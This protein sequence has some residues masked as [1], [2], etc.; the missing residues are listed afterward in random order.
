VAHPSSQLD[1]DEAVRRQLTMPPQA[2][3]PGRGAVMEHSALV[4]AWLLLAV[5]LLSLLAG[6]LS[7]PYPIV[8]VVGGGLLGFLPGVPEVHLDPD[9]VLLVFLPPLLYGAAFFA[10]AN[11]LRANLR[12]VTANAVGLVL[13]TMCAVAWVAHELVPGMPWAVAFTLGAIVS[14]TDPLAAT[15]VMR[16]LDVPRRIVSSIEGE[17][18]FNDATALV[19]YRAAV[20]AV[21]AGTFSLADAGIRFVL[22]AIA[23]VVIGLAV[24]W[25]AA[26][27]RRRTSDVQISITLSLLTGYAAYVPA[28][29]LGASGVLAA[30]TAGLYMG[31]RGPRILPARVRLQGYFVWD[32]VDFLI[33]AVLFVLVGLQLRGVVEGLPDAPAGSLAVQA[34]AVVG[35]VV[36]VRL[37]WFFTVPYLVRALDRRPAQRARRI[38][39]RWR[40]VIAWSG[41][42]GSVSLAVAL[43]LPLT[44][45]TGEAF[46]QRDLVVFLT[47]A[48]ILFTLVVQ[49]L[50]LP[51][52]IRRL[53]VTGDDAE[54]QEE[55][56]ARMIVA[57][58]ALDQIDALAGEAWT[59][60]DSVARMR[61][62]YAYR[63]RRFA[64][65]AGK[66]EDDGYEERSLV[67]QQMMRLVLEAPLPLPTQVCAPAQDTLACLYRGAHSQVASHPLVDQRTDEVVPAFSSAVSAADRSESAAFCPT[68]CLASSTLSETVSARASV[69]TLSAIFLP[70]SRSFS[71]VGI[72]D[73]TNQPRPNATVPAA[74]GLPCVLRLAASGSRPVASAASLTPPTTASRADE[75]APRTPA[76]PLSS[77]PMT[78]AVNP[79]AVSRAR[80]TRRPTT[81][82]GST[83]SCNASTPLRS[84]SRV[85]AMSASMAAGSSGSERSIALPPGPASVRSSTRSR[86]SGRARPGV[87]AP[88]PAS[89]VTGGTGPPGTVPY[90]MP[91]V[92]SGHPEPCSG[93]RWC[94]RAWDRSDAVPTAPRQRAPRSRSPTPRR[95]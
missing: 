14:P 91:R 38:G 46:P 44:T 67:Y 25:L 81:R 75:A 21:V 45:V 90:V 47:F 83:L 28:D 30:V 76:S 74:N 87:V 62:F 10:N 84:D 36:G 4:V 80:S 9:V 35:V 24:G 56:R 42:R 11:D 65:R 51:A 72:S 43:A 61:D 33:N 63:K 15:T 29:L 41:M 79:R 68:V 12:G 55:T 71:A 13:V 73:P 17:G 52:V 85:R 95:R 2:P 92:L 50:S 26:E 66:I 78:L 5:A 64:A 1:V 22:G 93:C 37:A 40:L 70:T 27:V 69:S 86:S 39:A 48:V 60:D 34:L 49:G 82:D 8:L 3:G 77:L 31:L 19:A 89:G 32:I 23:G 16:R 53:G 59:R 54:Q 94:V 57:K 58:A 88:T 18:L 6:R 7:V 20:A